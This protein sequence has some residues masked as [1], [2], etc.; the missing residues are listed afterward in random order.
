MSLDEV[1]SETKQ[2]QQDYLQILDD[3]LEKVAEKGK[4]QGA[5]LSKEIS[6]IVGKETKYKGKY[7]GEASVNSI[8]PEIAEKLNK[9]IN[10]PQNL[11]GS[12]RIFIGKDKVY[13]AKD[14]EVIADNLGL[15]NKINQSQQV[16][17]SKPE[18]TESQSQQVTESKPEVTESQSQ[19]VTESK[20]EVTESQ[21]FEELQRQIETLQQKVQEQQTIINTFTSQSNQPNVDNVQKLSNEL[22]SLK[23]AFDT[24]R[25]TIEKLQKGL[26]AIN[27]KSNPAI[28]NTRLQGW[29][30]S[31]ESAVKD[32]AKYL[33][34]QVK[35]SLTPTSEKIKSQLETQINSLKEQINQQVES[36]KGD[37]KEH[38]VAIKSEFESQVGVVKEGIAEV[39]QLV[40]DEI[41]QGIDRH[42]AATG[43]I[44]GKIAEEVNV[45]HKQVTKA[46]GDIHSAANHTVKQGVEQVTKNLA[47]IQAKALTKNVDN[48]LRLFG[49]RNN[50]GSIS[51]STKNYNFHQKDGSITVTAKDGRPV[52]SD[53]EFTS[54]TTEKDIQALEQ[55]GEIVSDYIK[56]KS[57]SQSRTSKLTR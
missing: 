56:P 3:I 39:K 13:H 35:N 45:V 25:Q 50:D 33:Y 43:A 12:V 40:N 27:Q 26:E 29:V 5:D 31:V 57:Q 4:F 30:S 1:K 46:V 20:P 23:Q 51:Y 54:T 34:R 16:T 38:L 2:V 55:V 11:K 15:T 48:A 37:V 44:Q 32:T 41:Q 6:I 17:E 19:Q 22:I 47:D 24:Q 14:G 42:Q 8:S 10:D 28:K 21:V 7:K 53:G 49:N 52:V 18:V 9:A 36:L